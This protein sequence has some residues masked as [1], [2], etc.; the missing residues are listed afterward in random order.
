MTEKEDLEIKKA[1]YARLKFVIEQT[2][3]QDI[4]SI[5]ENEYHSALESLKSPLNEDDEM[6]A[7]GALKFIDNFMAQINSEINFGKVAQEK[8]VKKYI[9]SQEG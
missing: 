2:G 7:R 6:K 4:L 1:K 9:E 8:Y 3:W 5:L